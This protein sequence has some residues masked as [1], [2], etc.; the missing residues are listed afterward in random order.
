M[1][2]WL[3]AVIFLLL[4]CPMAEGG[5]HK[6]DMTYSLLLDKGGAAAVHDGL[7]SGQSFRLR[8][9][10]RQDLFVYL[11]V[12]NGEDDFR[13][14]YPN[15]DIDRGKNQLNKKEAMVWPTRGWLRLD[16]NTGTD[17][18]YLILSVMPITELETRFA[19]RE[20]GF[21]EDLLLDIR[22]RYQDSGRYR[23]DL[24]GAETRVRF[25]SPD[26]PAVLVEE[27]ALRH[28]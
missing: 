20:Q 4:I 12:E 3:P 25:K 8:L 21:S 7:L 10:A 2:R 22:D 27:I 19:M 5:Q 17:R 14:L 24:K 15:A 28:L 18:M 6:I 13:L 11:V 1:Q 9:A 23:R 16:D 26:Q